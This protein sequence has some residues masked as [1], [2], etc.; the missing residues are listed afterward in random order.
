[1]NDK[2]IVNFNDAQYQESLKDLKLNIRKL[3]YALDCIQQITGVRELK[4]LDEIEKFICTK[5]GFENLLAS[6]E[7]LN[8][9]QPLVFLQSHLNSIEHDKIEKDSNTF[10]IKD[11]VLKDLKISFTTYLNDDF[12]SDYHL[13]S[14]AIVHLNKLT[15]PTLVNCLS[16]NYLGQYSVNMNALQ[17]S[18]LIC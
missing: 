18:R 1:M 7:L 16:R 4:T 15:T 13:L 8:V 2:I 3:E 12:V 17:N 6:A 9:L 11:S 5:S 14:K 10:K